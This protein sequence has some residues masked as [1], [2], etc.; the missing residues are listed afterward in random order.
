MDRK[1]NKG[2]VWI[3]IFILI[4]LD[5]IIKIIVKNYYGVNVPIIKSLI[6]FKPTLNED[7]S[8]INSIFNFGWSKLFHIVYILI[9]LFIF[10]YAFKYIYFKVGKKSELEALEVF[11]FS[12]ALCSLIDKIFWNGS[13]DY[14][15]L[16]GFFVF[17]LKDCYITA[18]EV[19]VIILI[20]KNWTNI[21][22]IEN[23]SLIKDYIE[24]IK[25]DFK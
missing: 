17:D 9:G 14:I 11:L 22:K 16:K 24:F 4:A 12:G 15:F 2:F 19:L 23:M 7:Y 8:W 25:R 21:S 3:S 5:Q 10:Y 13:L 20:T 18:F 6:Y 1:N